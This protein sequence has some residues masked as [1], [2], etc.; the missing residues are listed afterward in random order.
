MHWHG[1]APDR[2]FSHMA[3]SETSEGTSWGGQV[4]DTEYKM[5]PV[6]N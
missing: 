4:S 3:M 1:A 6:A 2:P 5:G